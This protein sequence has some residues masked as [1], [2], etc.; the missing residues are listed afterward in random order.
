MR[1]IRDSLAKM[2][3]GMLPVIDTEVELAD[4]ERGLARLE[5][6]QVFGKVILNL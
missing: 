6:R 4:F 1:N 5:G 3:G 2:A